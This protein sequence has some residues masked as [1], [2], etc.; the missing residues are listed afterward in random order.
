MPNSKYTAGF[1]FVVSTSGQAP[2]RQ[3]RRA[4]KSHATRAQGKRRKGA[5][6]RSW[7][8]P[9]RK[10]DPAERDSESPELPIALLGPRRVGGDLSA[11]QVPD[12][13]EPAFL[14]DLLKI[15]NFNKVGTY[16]YEVCLK[17][18]PVER[19]WFPYMI[20]DICCIHTMLFSASAF[21]DGQVSVERISA[22]AAFHHGQTLN[23]LQ[24][25]LDAFERGQRDAL[26]DS[27]LMVIILLIGAANFVGDFAAAKNHL[28]GLL[29]IVNLRGGVRSLNTHNNLQVKVCRA[30]LELS[31]S[32]GNRPY[33][34]REGLSWDCFLA[35]RAVIRCSHEP[36]EAQVQHFVKSKLDARLA[37]CWKDLHAFSCLSNL[38]FQT[39]GTLSPV[40]YHEAM[41]SIIY[42]LAHLSFEDATVQEAIRVGL[43]VFA[44]TLFITR[45]RLSLPLQGLLTSLENCL[46]VLHQSNNIDL[47]LP[48]AL[49]LIASYLAVVSEQAP[50][51]SWQSTRLSTLIVLAKV[52]TWSRIREILKS[53]M[54]VEFI[55]DE[56]GRKLFETLS[57]PP[58]GAS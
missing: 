55:H 28:A 44:S 8:D 30:D 53:I 43:L 22:R 1:H 48:I 56:P 9:D 49:W 19:G 2:T 18:H 15:I 32:L 31:L 39:T 13:I 17:V 25:R 21:L 51:K 6:L 37:N 20:S 16:P 23:H 33:L 11:L 27:T 3:D 40:T 46:F 26:S 4:I 10:L 5:Q 52:D 38:A 50:P 57:L 45:F 7:I 54:W 35:D 12:G 36:Y 47:P 29:K 42:R 24:T 34:F 14:Q 58:K 41:I